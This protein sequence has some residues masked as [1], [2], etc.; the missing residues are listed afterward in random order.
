MAPE[1]IATIL[2]VFVKWKKTITQSVKEFS[3]LLLFFLVSMVIFSTVIFFL[4]EETNPDFSSIPASFWWTVVTM[5]TV[6]YGDVVPMTVGGKCVGFVCAL[7]GV[8][9]IALPVPSIVQNFRRIYQ[10][11]KIN[12]DKKEGD[13]VYILQDELKKRFVHSNLH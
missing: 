2:K 5:T 7:A 10:E 3:F 6:G 11:D 8:L 9:C 1:S 4:E 12:P 13:N